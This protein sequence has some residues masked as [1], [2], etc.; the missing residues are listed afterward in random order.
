MSYAPVHNLVD[1][2]AG[3]GGASFAA[4]MAIEE[5]GG[6]VGLH[7]ALNHDGIALSS[8]KANHPNAIHIQEDIRRVNPLHWVIPGEVDGYVAGVDCTHHSQAR[9]GKPK[10][11]RQRALAWD[12]IRWCRLTHPRFIVVENVP[13]FVEW[14]PVDDEGK[15][16]AHRKGEYFQEWLSAFRRLGYSV[17]WKILCAAHY[18]DATTRRRF[19][20]IAKRADCSAITW[21]SPLR[22]L[23]DSFDGKKT[24]FERW[25]REAFDGWT[26]DEFEALNKARPASEIIDWNLPPGESIWTRKKPLAAATIARIMEGLRRY[27]G[28]P[29]IVPQLSGARV[30][31]VDEPLNTFTA[32]GTGNALIQPFLLGIGGPMGRQVVTGIDKPLGA[33][34]THNHTYLATPFLVP[35]FS[36]RAGQTPRTHSLDAPLPAVTGHG[37]GALV[38]PLVMNYNGNGACHPIDIGL[39]TV[40]TKDRLA[41]IETVASLQGRGVTVIWDIRL[42]MLQYH[43]LAASH[44][45]PEDV[46]IFG[47]KKD[48]VRQVGG[49]WPVMLGKAVVGEALQ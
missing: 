28:G 47:T 33:I 19:F 32:T 49:S 21:P 31:S 12:V 22:R 38:S 10:S 46:K 16:I 13:E 9:G 40:T 7:L 30:R 17:E 35:N 29:F 34:L 36:E 23:T 4:T 25:D 26:Q 3:L 2:F 43:E 1:M 8:H 18:G 5:R 44:S 15:V 14:G 45:F 42:R 24:P 11:A 41:L 48:K 39:P 27:V 6:R 37:A 20:C